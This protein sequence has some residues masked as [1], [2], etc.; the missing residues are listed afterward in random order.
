MK[1]GRT[2]QWTF[3]VT[4]SGTPEN[5]AGEVLRFTLKRQ[6]TDADADALVQAFSGEIDGRVTVTDATAGAG[7]V[8]LLPADTRD[9]PDWEVALHWDLVVVYEGGDQYEVD[10]GVLTVDPAASR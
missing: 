2:K 10:S 6:I 1:R 4:R 5:I 9:L 3:A 8:R 7:T